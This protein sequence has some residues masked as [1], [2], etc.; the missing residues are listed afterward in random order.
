[1]DNKTV[2]KYSFSSKLKQYIQLNILTFTGITIY[3][4]SNIQPSP[5]PV[6]ISGTLKYLE[7]WE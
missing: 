4:K 7:I 5:S 2:I 3:P 1:M 6:L